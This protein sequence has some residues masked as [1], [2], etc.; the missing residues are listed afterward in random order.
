[1][2]K[3]I[4]PFIIDSNA[5]LLEALQQ[6]DK[7]DSK[8]LLVTKNHK[9]KSILSAGDIQRSLLKHNNF[10]LPIDKALRKN[11]KLGT[12]NQSKEEI[13]SLMLE[14]R[15]EFMPIVDENY[16]LVD[17]IFW[18]DVYKKPRIKRKID[19]SIPV[20]IM[21]GG[22]GTRLRPLT[23][24]IPKP[25]I[26]VGDKPFI[27]NIINSFNEH[28]LNSFY[29][30]VNYKADLIKYYFDNI[31]KNYNVDYFHE[32]EPLGTAGSLHLMKDKITSTFFVSNCDIIINQDYDEIYEYHKANKNE[33][34]A[35]AAVKTYNIPYGTMDIGQDGLLNSLK[36]KPELT[37]YVNAGL[38]I[39]E[40]HLLK[41]IPQN[42]FFHI[43][44]LMEK[45]KKRNGNVGVFP[46]SEGSWTDIGDWKEYLSHILPNK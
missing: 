2:N 7:L 20:V 30:S 34:T 36:E 1:M 23:H 33:L 39:L 17:V 28:G 5:T 6:M 9:F 35:V 8:L 14:Y 16:N 29:L 45:I 3:K 46:V 10:E 40:P 37:Y 11:I 12:S 21:A 42:E 27:E 26:P 25:L 22:K 15:I 19:S 18:Q 32:N 44:H 31:S 13:K 24:V 43:T 41:E 4:T 38:Y